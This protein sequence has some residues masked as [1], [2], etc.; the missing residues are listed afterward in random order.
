M[1]QLDRAQNHQMHRWHRHLRTSLIAM[2]VFN[3]LTNTNVSCTIFANAISP[4]DDGDP[5]EIGERM[6]IRYTEQLNMIVQL[7]DEPLAGN[8]VSPKKIV[9]R[10]QT[11]FDK[12]LDVFP[13]ETLPHA[14][15]LFAKLCVKVGQYEKSLDLFDEAIRRASIPLNENRDSFS[16]EDADDDD[17]IPQVSQEVTEAEALVKQ[18]VLERNRAHF[19][20]LQMQIDK[21]DNANI[22][23]HKGGIP[24][25]TSP[26]DPLGVVEHQLKIFPN[27]H[28]QSLFDKASLMVL[29]LDSPSE[30]D[31][32]N[33]T[34]KAWESYEIFTKAQ[35]WA[36]GAYTHGK[37]RNLAGGKPCSGKEYGFGMA[38][39]GRAWSNYAM[40]SHPFQPTDSNV[41]SQSYIG[42][43]TLQNVIISGK[44][45]VISGYGENCQVFVPHRF[46]NL[47]DNLP[48]VT[49][50]ES[51]VHELT[52]GDNPLWLTHMPFNDHNAYGGKIDKDAIGND[53]L[54][55]PDPKPK[56]ASRGFDSAVLLTRYASYNY[57]HFVTEVL[58]SLVMMKD[59]VNSAISQSSNGGKGN[60]KDIVIVPNMQH[61][62]VT[63]FL[64][65]L[66][67]NAWSDGALSKHIV[68]WGAPTR[69]SNVTSKFLTSHPLTYVRRLYAATWDQPKEA[70]P[71]VSGPAHCLTPRPLLYAMQQYVWNAVDDFRGRRNRDGVK[72]RVVYC[73]RS[74]SAARSLKQENELFALINEAVSVLDGE[75]EVIRFE[76]QVKETNSTSSSSP[77]D[78]IIDS[79]ELFRSATVVVGVHGASL[80]NVAFCRPGTTVVELG[81]EGLPQ[82]SHYRHLSS[83]LG[84]KHVDVWLERDSRSLGATHVELRPGGVQKVVDAVVTGL[85][86]KLRRHSEL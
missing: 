31:S 74:S 3:L 67:P 8:D 25:E 45:A 14:H 12:A 79:V 2:L 39:G 84:L 24:P 86:Q 27:P 50:W 15:A 10:G 33:R 85:L 36:F 30:D 83:A 41:E 21:W 69:N 48:M 5:A 63:G 72:L 28:P 68:Q 70:P 1:S 52:M 16:N 35:T 81:F 18:L 44:E 49:S 26:M 75:V 7:I 66:L 9:S 40:E 13:D 51:S 19:S 34:A 37:K 6:A 43:V 55:I 22:A 60:P 78:F 62:F 53:V 76:K 20:H 64:R 47:A 82:A 17:K 59:R 73:S 58:P 71:P 4:D 23:L 46:V 42:V 54:V 61:D 32:F 65:L 56:T 80:A 57:Y 38:V 77:L 11:A 29:L